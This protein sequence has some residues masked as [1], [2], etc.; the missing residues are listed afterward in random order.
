MLHFYVKVFKTKEPTN[1]KHKVF[2]ASCFEEA[3][4]KAY[5]WRLGLSETGGNTR[6]WKFSEIARVTD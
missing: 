2:S 3:V 1:T 6:E 4:S 5:V